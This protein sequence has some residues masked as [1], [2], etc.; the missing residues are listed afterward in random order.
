MADRVAKSRDLAAQS[1]P[2]AW[3]KLSP[4]EGAGK[5]GCA[6]QRAATAAIR[7]PAAY[8]GSTAPCASIVTVTAKTDRYRFCYNP[9]PAAA[10][11]RR[12]RKRRRLRQQ[13]CLEAA[14]R[15]PRL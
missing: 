8:D 5:T 11:F 15:P 12:D 4:N 6:L 10:A 9:A 14:S 7:S 3:P 13:R 2:E 1:A